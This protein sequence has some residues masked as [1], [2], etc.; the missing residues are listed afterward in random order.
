MQKGK[1]VIFNGSLKTRAKVNHFLSELKL[2][3][4]EKKITQGD[5]VE[6]AIEQAEK[7]PMLE[8]ENADLKA[9]IKE[10]EEKVKDFE[11]SE[12]VRMNEEDY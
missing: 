10:L 8:K 12:Y 9:R 4:P 11:F 7:V 6:Y 5:A 1:V 2:K 3:D